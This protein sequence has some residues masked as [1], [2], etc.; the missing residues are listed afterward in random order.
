MIN[1]FLVTFEY[2]LFDSNANNNL[3][4]SKNGWKI[5]KLMKH[6]AGKHMTNL[7]GVQHIDFLVQCS[8]S[9]LLCWE[10]L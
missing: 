6:G 1:E 8:T 5:Y 4:L 2:S 3:A 7:K 10:C 9:F